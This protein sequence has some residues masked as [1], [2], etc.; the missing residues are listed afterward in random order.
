MQK[1][2]ILIL[3]YASKGTLMNIEKQ[4]GQCTN[5]VAEDDHT[6]SMAK[7]RF[8]SCKIDKKGGHFYAARHPC[9]HVR[10]FQF[11]Q[12]KANELL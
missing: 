1:I 6:R 4:C 8:K 2:I 11:T 9:N 5:W 7:H 10:Y 12:T 3:F